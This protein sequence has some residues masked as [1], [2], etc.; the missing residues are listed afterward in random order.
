MN[1]QKYTFIVLCCQTI[2][3]ELT[4]KIF[5]QTDEK[6]SERRW[7]CCAGVPVKGT[8]GY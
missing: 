2:E 6:S 4:K 3:E 1:D 7:Q 5:L 8:P